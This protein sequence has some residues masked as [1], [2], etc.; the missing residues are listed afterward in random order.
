MGVTQKSALHEPIEEAAMGHGIRKI[1]LSGDFEK[2]PHTVTGTQI[3]DG[4]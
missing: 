2:Q 1:V 4:H 3:T